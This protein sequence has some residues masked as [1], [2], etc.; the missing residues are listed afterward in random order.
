MGYLTHSSSV[1]LELGLCAD[2]QVYIHCHV[3]TDRSYV[4]SND[5]ATGEYVYM[6][7]YAMTL[8]NKSFMIYTSPP[9]D[10]PLKRIMLTIRWDT[11]L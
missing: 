1:V 2:E 7:I 10:Y 11:T 8:E 4:D 5:D 6:N 3:G 9:V